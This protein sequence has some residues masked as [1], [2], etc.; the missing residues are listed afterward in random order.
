MKYG[1]RLAHMAVT[2]DWFLWQ[3]DGRV[4]NLGFSTAERCQHPF[5]RFGSPPNFFLHQSAQLA[6]IPIKSHCHFPGR[7]AV[8]LDLKIWRFPFSFQA[9]LKGED[10]SHPPYSSAEKLNVA[11]GKPLELSDAAM[12]KVSFLSLQRGWTAVTSPSVPHHESIR[13]RLV[14]MYGLSARTRRMQCFGRS[15]WT[16]RPKDVHSFLMSYRVGL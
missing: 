10:R 9:A 16:I 7:I 1:T 3:D 2:Q 8:C 4:A 11:A 6:S 14:R 15:V 12:G 13:T 5:V